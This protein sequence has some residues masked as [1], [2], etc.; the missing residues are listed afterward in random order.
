MS[1]LHVSGNQILNGAGQPVRLLGVNRSGTQYA[2]V[3]GW[4]FFDGPADQAS[5]DAMKTW[6][7]NAVRVSLNESCWLGKPGIPAA[8]SGANY[9]NAIA[10]WVNLLTS[11]GLA[12]VVDLH[13]SAPGNQVAGANGDG[14]QSMPNRDNS[15]VF[16][17]QVANRFKG[18]SAVLFDLFNE[19]HPGAEAVN[20][21][22]WSCWRN[23]ATPTDSCSD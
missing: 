5:I 13:W 1:G 7:I 11:N 18:N 19:T 17:T 2:C 14:Q 8:Y 6:H 20:T 4:G 21:R 15:P 12:V 16:W 3:G 9:Q 22:D 23:G 10:N